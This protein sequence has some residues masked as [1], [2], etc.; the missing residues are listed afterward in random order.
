MRF[1]D[2]PPAATWRRDESKTRPE[3][4]Q[5]SSAA[6]AHALPQHSALELSCRLGECQHFSPDDTT[7]NNTTALYCLIVE[8][9]MYNIQYWARSQLC[10][11]NNEQ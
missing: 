8:Q 2:S 4:K 6:T 7:L 9:K 11:V 1:G 5:L 3:E 10:N